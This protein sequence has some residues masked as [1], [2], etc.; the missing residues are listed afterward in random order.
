VTR[1]GNKKISGCGKLSYAGYSRQI[2]RDV[3]FSKSPRLAASKL[4]VYC[5]Y[6]HRARR[7]S[8]RLVEERFERTTRRFVTAKKHRGSVYFV[9]EPSLR[10]I[11]TQG[12]VSLFRSAFGRIRL[13]SSNTRRGASFSRSLF[14][15][16]CFAK[17]SLR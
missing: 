4:Q 13:N 3:C 7:F 5:G 11:V 8:W 2:V 10:S 15:F 6:L 1:R 9:N 14:F 12:F 16:R 17:A